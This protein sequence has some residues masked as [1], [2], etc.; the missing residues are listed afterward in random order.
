MEASKGTPV[1]LECVARIRLTVVGANG[2]TWPCKVRSGPMG[3]K[4]QN[5]VQGTKTKTRGHPDLGAK[6]SLS[7]IWCGEG[8]LNPHGVTR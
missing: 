5:K 6:T 2:F 7:S 8:D 1:G 3:H 4:V